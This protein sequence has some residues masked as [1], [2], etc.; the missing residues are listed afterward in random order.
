M[1]HAL[2]IL[3]ALSRLA[4]ARTVSYTLSVGNN[5]PPAKETRLAT[6]RFADDDA[7]RYSQFFS[8][9]AKESR[10]LTVMDA[11]TQRRHPDLAARA[12]SLANLNEIV[13][14]FAKR[15]EADRKRGDEPIFYFSFSGHGARDESG[16]YLSFLDG[17]MTREMLYE[18]VVGRVGATF[19]HLIV[20]ACYAAG[21]VGVR[22][23]MFAK[24]INTQP[25]ELSQRELSTLSEE[26]Q[27]RHPTVG[28]LVAASR[29]G[30]AR[31]WSGIEAGVFSH[32][33]LSGLL[34]GA[35]VNG[36]GKIEYSELE[37]FA[38]AAN[39]NI[40]D[41]RALPQVIARSPK[42]FAHAPLVS[43]ADL[44]ASYFLTG[45]AAHLGHFSVELENGERYLDAHYSPDMRMMLALPAGRLLFVRT[46]TSEAE[47]PAHEAGTVA[48]ESL[49]FRPKKGVTRGAIETAY[50]TALFS[51]PFGRS[52]YAGF[53]DST[54]SLSVDFEVHRFQPRRRPGYRRATAITLFSIAGAATVVS[55]I[56]G[57]VA[58][59]AKREYDDTQLQLSAMDA[60]SRYALSSQLSLSSAIGAAAT[61]VAGALVWPRTK[62]RPLVE[63][64]RDGANLGIS[65]TW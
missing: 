22:G 14:E 62:Y 53:A 47:L 29:D 2:F 43:L 51:H 39:R 36:D 1:K 41:P 44:R 33:V 37:A 59:A 15:M 38:A 11:E 34:G 54:Q 26:E 56:S 49:A 9:F 20:D 12:P 57:A 31:E 50:R 42:I 23:D 45:A 10:L 55:I 46:E 60:F 21:V 18:Q 13:D 58:L 3:L 65:A 40:R 63:V 61:S 28:V 7:V 24:E 6:L 30:L 48:V 17:K 25:V 52:Y 32:E 64:S 27:S 19:S 8:R 16:A 5:S 35:D 4:A